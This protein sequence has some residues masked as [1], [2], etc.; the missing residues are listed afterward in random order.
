MS[1]QLTNECLKCGLE[2]LVNQTHNDCNKYLESMKQNLTNV[3]Y[4]I[5]INS[6][7]FKQATEYLLVFRYGPIGM[8]LYNYICNPNTNNNH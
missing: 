5:I 1:Y 4:D 3:E 8:K 2:Y 6:A 7:N